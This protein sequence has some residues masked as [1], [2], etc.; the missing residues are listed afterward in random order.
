MAPA[1]NVNANLTVSKD[2]NSIT[3]GVSLDGFPAVELYVTNA[4]G[5]TMSLLLFDP[6]AAGNG[7]FSLLPGLGD[8]QQTVSCS[9]VNSGSC[10]PAPK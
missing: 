9:G 8:Q 10:T 7:A 1:I 6:N 2:G 4:Q 3:G 5:Q